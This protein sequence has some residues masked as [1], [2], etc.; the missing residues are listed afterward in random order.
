MGVKRLRIIAGPNGSG[1]STFIN[2]VKSTPPSPSFKL[3]FY[4]NADDIEQTLKSDKTLDFNQ[5]GLEVTTANIQSHFKKSTF[6]PIKLNQA[7]LWE[8]FSI[9]NNTLIIHK[10]QK[11]NSYIAADIAEFIRQQLLKSEKSFSYETVMS[12]SKKIDFLRKAKRNNYRT[13][14]Y[15]FATEDPLININRVEL[16][17]AQNGHPVKRET[18]KKRYYRSLENLKDAIKLSD[19]AYLFDNSQKASVLIAEITDGKN[20]RLFDP[21][22][23]PNWFIKYVVE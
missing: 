22:A 3:G 19:R 14:L 2:K 16:R 1:K 5:Y 21:S 4:V 7:N 23:I 12:D 18:I 8:H 20:V 13:Y 9:S 15:F 11:I 17:V 6:A 10:S